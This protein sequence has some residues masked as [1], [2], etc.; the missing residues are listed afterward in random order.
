MQKPLV[1]GI[2]INIKVKFYKNIT[3]LDEDQTLGAGAL[4]TQ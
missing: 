4:L 2:M 1:K 3:S